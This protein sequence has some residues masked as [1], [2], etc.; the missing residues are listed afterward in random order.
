MPDDKY[1][2][3]VVWDNQ[4]LI[5]LTEDTVT[6]GS[7]L[8]GVT[9]HGANGQPLTGTL[10]FTQ[11]QVDWDQ[12][13]TTAV[14]YIKNKPSIINTA[15]LLGNWFKPEGG[16]D[17][18][19]RP[20]SANIH[21]GDTA[22]VKT[23]LATSSMTTGKPAQDGNILHFEWDN[24]AR[25]ST[26]LA[27][28]HGQAPQYRYQTGAGDTAA[29]WSSWYSFFTEQNL[30]TKVKGIYTNNGGI[31]PPN[32]FGT[33]AVGFLMSN[34]TVN[35]DSHYK[36]IMYMDCYHGSDVGGVTALALDRTEARA[37]ILQS[38]ANRTSW[39]NSTELVTHAQCSTSATAS[40]VAKRDANGYL[41][42][43]YLNTSN[44]REDTSF[45]PTHLVYFNNGSDGYLRKMYASTL[46]RTFG[47]H[48]LYHERKSGTVVSSDNRVII[49]EGYYV[50]YG[51]GE[52]ITSSSAQSMALCTV[53]MRVHASADT[54]TRIYFC[55][56]L[57]K[58]VAPVG[59][60]PISYTT[61]KTANAAWYYIGT[62][63][64][65]ISNTGTIYKNEPHCI[66]VTYVTAIV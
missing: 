24:G 8:R 6:A 36:N 19:K 21:S 63:G 37:F 15:K 38:N 29:D 30:P 47:K 57:P 50:I 31:Q 25:Y 9:A 12:T 45:Q 61:G 48:Y 41:F 17:A 46:A 40:T 13:D 58:P 33:N 3:K 51:C 23:F 44:S 4:T 53:T 59:I 43:T 22:G 26:Q 52:T 16:Y 11:V 54:S 7:L 49:D 62:N 10:E 32:Y 39:T 42:C 2:N 27:M 35:S 56:A 64:Q 66:N 18:N 14:D 60:I 20:T 34:V 55:S 1:Y 65:G 28:L 5:D